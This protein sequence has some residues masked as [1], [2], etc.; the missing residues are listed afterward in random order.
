MCDLFLRTPV[1]EISSTR[2]S[3]FSRPESRNIRIQSDKSRLECVSVFSTRTKLWLVVLVFILLLNLLSSLTHKMFNII[4]SFS[5][6]HR[7]SWPL[8]RVTWTDICMS[9]W[10]CAAW[11]EG[12]TCRWRRAGEW[13]RVAGDFTDDSENAASL[14]KTAYSADLRSEMFVVFKS[15]KETA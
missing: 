15:T 5:L 11:N 3:L 8:L 7:W 6:T 2:P 9:T 14:I 1:W 12:W 4:V 13:S 10:R